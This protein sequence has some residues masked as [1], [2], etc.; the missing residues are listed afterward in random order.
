MTNRKKEAEGKV[1]KGIAALKH[2]STFDPEIR[3]VEF[4]DQWLNLYR[5][6]GNKETTVKYREYCLSV[7]N[8]YLAKD[9]I[10]N[11]TTV[12]YQGVI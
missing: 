12:R 8:K 11:I 6:K 9:K 4:S 10:I 5:L 2:Q 7:L 1:K 3:F